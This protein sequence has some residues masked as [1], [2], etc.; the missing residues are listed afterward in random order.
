MLLG[1]AYP[2]RIG[3]SRAR[4]GTN[5]LLSGGKGV[6]LRPG[7]DLCASEYL[8]APVLNGNRIQ[9]AAPLAADDL[10]RYFGGRFTERDRV[11][12]DRD[13]ER[14]AAVRETALGSL[15]LKSAPLDSAEPAECARILARA[16]GET[17]IH[18]L[19]LDEAAENLR[20]RVR[21]AA[22]A[23]GGDWPDWSDA[24]LLASLPELLFVRPEVKSFAELRRL[25]WAELLR[26]A[27][28]YQQRSQL[29]RDFPERFEAPTGSKLKI[30]YRSDVPVLAVRVQELYGLKTHPTLGA[31]K[32]PLKLELL[33]PARRPIQITSDLPRFWRENWQIVRKEMR[34]AYPKHVWPE[35]PAEAA[36][37]TRAKSR[38]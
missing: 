25:P 35:A 27:L 13:R 17:G 7:D 14:V 32:L 24:G 18:V 5:Y 30:D 21:F 9:L 28:S 6:E 1:Y 8:V 37:T 16:V 15:V 26:A 10:K 36:P 29:D 34:A 38:N 33:S 4:L 12:F 11:F 19:G 23:A 2:D 22:A 31:G 3:R 20:C